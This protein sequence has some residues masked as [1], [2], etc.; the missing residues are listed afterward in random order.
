MTALRN[1]HNASALEVEAMGSHIQ[2]HHPWLETVFQASLN[3]E[4]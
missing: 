2:G 3:Y 4:T 1:G